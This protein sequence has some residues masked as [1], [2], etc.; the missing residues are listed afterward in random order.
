MTTLD[1]SA[2]TSDCYCHHYAG[3]EAWCEEHWDETGETAPER[4][5][6]DNMKHQHCLPENNWKPLKK[7]WEANEE[8]GEEKGYGAK[9]HQGTTAHVGCLMNEFIS[10]FKLLRL[11]NHLIYLET[12]ILPIF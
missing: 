11:K 7:S 6:D 12:S 10:A 8:R 9:M 4:T 3:N 5:R 1:L 2:E